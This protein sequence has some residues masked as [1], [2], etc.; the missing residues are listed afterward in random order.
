MKATRAFKKK[1]KDRSNK[2]KPIIPEDLTVSSRV[3]TFLEKSLKTLTSKP[4]GK[5]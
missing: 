4:E 3:F 1:Y 2:V 5:E